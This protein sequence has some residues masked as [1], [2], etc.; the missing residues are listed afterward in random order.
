MHAS[1][2]VCRLCLAGVA[3]TD[4]VQVKLRQFLGADYVDRSLAQVRWVLGSWVLGA[5]M[6]ALGGLLSR[7]LVCAKPWLLATRPP[8]PAA[9]HN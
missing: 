5:E 7:Q 2:L 6:K 4:A 3:L 1:L 8:L 9:V